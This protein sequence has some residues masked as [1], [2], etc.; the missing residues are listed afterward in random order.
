M[1]VLLALKPPRKRGKG[2]YLKYVGGGPEGFIN[3]SKKNHSPGDHRPK[4]FMAQ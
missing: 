3:F 1:L 2:V 4:Y